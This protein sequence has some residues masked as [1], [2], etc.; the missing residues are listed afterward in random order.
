MKNY[1]LIGL[2]G[3]TGAGKGQVCSFFESNGYAVID[4]DFLARKAVENPL[5]LTLL[6]RNFG[7]DILDGGKL[8]RKLL[9]ARAF[10]SK[11]KTAL[12]NSI[13]HPF[14]SA[15]FVEEVEKL[16]KGGADK[17]VFD[18]PQLFESR[19]NILCDIVIAVTADEKIRKERIMS[20]DALSEELAEKRISV[21]FSTEFFE[22]N[23]DFIIE[24][25]SHLQELEEKT[26]T[27]I[28]KIF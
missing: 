8:N 19:L 11:E 28:E 1:K 21:Q 13:T 5:V 3:T 26:Q 10:A 14:I 9:G 27:I 24:N 17:I 12:L 16:V 4:A 2:T 25:N 15:I 22:E 18:A 20:R 6:A 23:C 7:D